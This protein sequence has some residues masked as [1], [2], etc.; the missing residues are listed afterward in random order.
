MSIELGAD[1]PILDT[2]DAFDLVLF[3][4]FPVPEVVTELESADAEFSGA[5]GREFN[6]IPSRL[7]DNEFGVEIVDGDDG[8]DDP[9]VEV[10]CWL[11][12][13]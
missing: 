3:F 11:S 7:I 4:L 8:D 2:G 13:C 6:I 10:V 12:S 5:L 1:S 9:P